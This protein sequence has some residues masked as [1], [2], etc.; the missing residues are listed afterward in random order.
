MFLAFGVVWLTACSG[1][2][3]WGATREFDTWGE[4]LDKVSDGL[5]TERE[6]SLGRSLKAIVTDSHFLVPFVVLLAGIALLVA[7]H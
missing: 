7:L 3:D 5:R 2:L 6:M 1:W 4:C